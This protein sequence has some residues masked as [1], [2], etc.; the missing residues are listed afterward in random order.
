MRVK[1]VVVS[2]CM[3]FVIAGGFAISSL[4]YTSAKTGNTLQPLSELTTQSQSE[5]NKGLTNPD[6]IPDRLA[7]MLL[8]RFLSNPLRSQDENVRTQ[9]RSYLKQAR[10]GRRT[11]A[12]CPMADPT[13]EADINVLIAAANEFQERVGVLDQQAVQ[14]KRQNRINPNPAI[15][16]Q[17]AELQQ[18]K[19]VIADSIVASLSARLSNHAKQELR[20]FIREHVKKNV[21]LNWEKL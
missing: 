7:Y 12:T 19:E 8:F 21:Q 20:R 18:R 10:L 13:D 2:L 4:S 9:A 1:I 14:L 17:L 11:C 6:D 3:I 15:T 16:A 5:V